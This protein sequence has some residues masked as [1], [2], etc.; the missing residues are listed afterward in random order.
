MSGMTETDRKKGG[1]RV[2]FILIPICIQDDVY[3]EKPF[4]LLA[5]R[6]AYPV[7]IRFH[8]ICELAV[9]LRQHKLA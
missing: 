8:S 1:S 9:P 7:T 4:L 2:V 6:A 3:W 5:L